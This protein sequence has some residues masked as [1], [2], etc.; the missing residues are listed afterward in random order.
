[1]LAAGCSESALVEQRVRDGDASRKML[2]DGCVDVCKG[3]LPDHMI[4][5]DAMDSGVERRE[6]VAWVYDRLVGEHLGA[7]P[8]S[9]DPDLAYAADPVACGL[10]VD[11]DEVG[12]GFEGRQFERVDTSLQ[13]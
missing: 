5:A 6:V 8:E 10:D 4:A 13:C 2:V 9:D 3:W 12:R 7:V 1:M 11:D